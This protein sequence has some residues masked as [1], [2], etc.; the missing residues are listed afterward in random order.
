[1]MFLEQNNV[2]VEGNM[3]AS[4]SSMAMPSD[5]LA[6]DDVEKEDLGILSYTL[7]NM[8]PR[9]VPMSREATWR[10]RRRGVSLGF[11]RQCPLSN[12]FVTWSL[13]HLAPHEMSASQVFVAFTEWLTRFGSRSFP[14]RH[15]IVCGTQAHSAHE[16][17]PHIC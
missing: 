1:M 2:V 15:S 4:N 17:S 8:N 6:V 11:P 10:P 16:G 7:A 13:E 5:R 14:G 3:E 12:S 9:V